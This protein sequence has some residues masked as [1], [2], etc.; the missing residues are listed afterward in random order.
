MVRPAE[1]LE[2]GKT[3]PCQENVFTTPNACEDVE[4]EEPSFVADENA[5]PTK[6]S[7]AVPYKTEHAIT[8]QYSKC[9]SWYLSKGVENLCPHKICTWT[10]IAVL[11]IIA[12]AWN[13]PNYP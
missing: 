5:K 10:F 9:D 11:F 1:L 3:N 2:G 4:Q 13:Q 7:L 12:Q 6:D 8:I